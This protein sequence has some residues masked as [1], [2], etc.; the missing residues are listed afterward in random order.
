MMEAAIVFPLLPRKNLAMAQFL[1]ELTEK[2]RYSHDRSHHMVLRESW[3]LQATLRGD[4][5][6]V[7]LEAPDPME[8]FAEL[9]VSKGEFEVWFRSQVLDLTGMDLTM[10]PPFCLPVRIL[11]RVRESALD[12]PRDLSPILEHSQ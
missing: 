1:H 7:Y 6:I 10:L 9:S 4:L 3:F 2:H 8:V 11:H 5:V 12:A